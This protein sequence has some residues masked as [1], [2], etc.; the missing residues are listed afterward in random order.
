MENNVDR[1]CRAFSN[2]STALSRGCIIALTLAN[3]GAVI[4]LSNNDIV[5]A[6]SPSNMMLRGGFELPNG[7]IKEL[8]SVKVGQS[9]TYC[10]PVSV[11]AN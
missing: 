8:E 9:L 4:A 11:R 10:N 1:L 7:T 2:A 5:S 3:S 6:Y